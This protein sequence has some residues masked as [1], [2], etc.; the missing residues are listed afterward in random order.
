MFIN[1]HFTKLLADERAAES[2]REAASVGGGADPT[3]KRITRLG[4]RRGRAKTVAPLG[5]SSPV[6]SLREP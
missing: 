6:V 2:R 1:N 3:W 5:S 4:R